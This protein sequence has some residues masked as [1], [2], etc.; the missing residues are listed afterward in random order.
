MMSSWWTGKFKHTWKVER[1]EILMDKLYGAANEGLEV[2]IGDT[3]C[4]TVTS[5]ING[6]WMTVNC[7]G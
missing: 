5:P 6:A 1:V 2:Y 3:L 4:G 7:E